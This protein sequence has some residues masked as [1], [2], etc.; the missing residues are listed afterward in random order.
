[1]PKVLWSSVTGSQSSSL[2]CHRQGYKQVP[3]DPNTKPPMA[4]YSLQRS[5]SDAVLGSFGTPC[6]MSFWGESAPDVI[7]S[8]GF[9]SQS[10]AFTALGQQAYNRAYAK[11]KDKAYTQAANMTALVEIAKTRSMIEKRML[12]LLKGAQLLRDGKFKEFLRNFGLKALKKHQ[13]K[14][15]SRPREFSGLWLEYWMGWAPTIGDVATSVETLTKVVPTQKIRAGSSVPLDSSSRQ[16]S[17]G[18][19]ATTD[20]V[21]TG[22]VW[23]NGLVTVTNPNL[24]LAQKLGLINVAKTVWE[25]VRMSFLVDWFTNIGQV[26]GQFTDWLGLQLKDLVVSVK[27]VATSSWLLT[28]AQA[29]FGPSYP[30][31]MKHKKGVMR[32]NRYVL[33]NGLPLVKPTI[34]LPDKL[35]LSRAAT[36]AS[37]LVSIFAPHKAK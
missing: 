2:Y 7:C 10:L 17:G 4:Y 20:I 8:S 36:S 27:T 11:F 22:T 5:M 28:G 24:H 6:G 37:L 13:H 30:P 29:I 9:D 16:K 34:S 1:M 32:F 18:S 15:W 19:I 26:L 31:V 21:G 3:F 25:T 12:Q 23:I 14:L 33:T 35:S